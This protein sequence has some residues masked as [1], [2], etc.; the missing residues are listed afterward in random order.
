MSKINKHVMIS[1]DLWLEFQ[2]III[3]LVAMYMANAET[4][5]QFF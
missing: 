4:L 3:V 2:I 1:Y 5:N